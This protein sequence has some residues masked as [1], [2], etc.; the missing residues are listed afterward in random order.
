[1]KREWK[2]QKQLQREQQAERDHLAAKPPSP[3]DDIVMAVVDE[4][5]ELHWLIEQDVLRLAQFFDTPA[6]VRAEVERR[7]AGIEH[8]RKIMAGVRA[9]R[10]SS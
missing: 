4:Q 8:T 5:Q 7:L 1:M 6:K 10:A 2:Q 3:P 9:W